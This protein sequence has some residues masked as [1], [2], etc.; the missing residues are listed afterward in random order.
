MNLK[1]SITLSLFVTLFFFLGCNQ[2]SSF[3]RALSY[4]KDAEYNKAINFYKI[5][6]KKGERI[7][8]SEKN[9]GDIFFGD[10]KYDKAFQY[11]KLSIEKDPSVAL[12]T[13]MKYISYND[14]RVRNFVGQ[15]F[16]E[17][18]NEQAIKLIEH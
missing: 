10:K 17:I 3:D 12:E 2:Q 18:N 4:Q 6:I 13:A 11:Y 7:A 15:M 5:S 9:I 8:E 16:S 14:A 1:R